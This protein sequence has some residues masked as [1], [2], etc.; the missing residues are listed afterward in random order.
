MNAQAQGFGG[1]AYA[2]AA[3]FIGAR[4]VSG[5]E[6]DFLREEILNSVEFQFTQ[7]SSEN[8]VTM[9]RTPEWRVVIEVDA[10]HGEKVLW[11]DCVQHGRWNRVRFWMNAHSV[12]GLGDTLRAAPEKR[13]AQNAIFAND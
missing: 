4:D 13:V 9:V 11:F 8:G 3:W 2:L 10:K 1:S 12:A 7:W 5:P 6:G